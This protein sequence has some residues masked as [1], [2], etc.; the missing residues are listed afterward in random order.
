M[1]FTK[2]LVVLSVL[3]FLVLFLAPV[4]AS[5]VV[6]SQGEYL[7]YENGTYTF[8]PAGT[9]SSVQRINDVWYVNGVVFTGG[10]T[11]FT[12]TVTQVGGGAISPDTLTVNYGNSVTFTFT[13][14]SD[15]GINA[16]VIDGNV[17]S[18]ASTY[19][20]TDVTATHTVS[21]EWTAGGN[22][23]L[24]TS[25]EP[26]KSGVP[27]ATPTPS[28]TKTSVQKPSPTT[29]LTLDNITN[30]IAI[31]IVVGGVLG[32]HFKFK[33]FSKIKIPKL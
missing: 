20:F 5:I 29:Y 21:V 15:V 3:V 27:V 22:S 7:G 28:P 12:I 8:L 13:P 30:A 16:L 25:G 19:T 11:V 1:H 23:Q 10:P 32:A 6:P 17:V 4:Y 14:N 18:P 33:I 9:Y 24:G 26:G 31:V 2:Q